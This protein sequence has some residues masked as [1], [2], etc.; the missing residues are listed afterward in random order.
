MSYN[1]QEDLLYQNKF[2]KDQE[3]QDVDQEQAKEFERY[4]EENQKNRTR[5]RLVDQLERDALDPNFAPDDLLNTQGIVQNT[6]LNI[7]SLGISQSVPREFLPFELQKSLFGGISGGTIGES[8]GLVNKGT[9]HKLGIGT[10][11]VKRERRTVVNIDSRDRDTEEYPD[12]NQFQI[13]L[14]RAYLNIKSIALITTEFPNAD[15]PVKR[16][17]ASIRNNKVVW[18]NQEDRAFGLSNTFPVYTADLTPGNYAASTLTD[19][20]TEKMNCVKRS[21]ASGE[22][23]GKNHYFDISIDLD[24]DIVEIHQLD[25]LPLQNNP[26]STT[27]QDQTVTVVQLN[28]PFEVGD[29]AFLTGLRGFVGG[30]SPNDLNGFHTVTATTSNVGNGSYGPILITELNNIIDFTESGTNKIAVV[31][32]TIFDNPTEL[33][34]NIAAALNLAG[35]LVYDVDFDVTASD[36]FTIS[37]ATT[38]FELNWAT[39]TNRGI[40]IGE[41]LGFD[42]T[43]D[44]TGTTSYTSD[45]NVPNS[46]WQFELKVDGVFT[47]IGGSNG[48]RAGSLLPFKFLFGS[49]LNTIGPLLGYPAED[50]S[51]DIVTPNTTQLTTFSNSVV[52]ASIVSGPPRALNINS[53]NHGLLSGDRI[54]IRDLVTTPHISSSGD[55]VGTGRITTFEVTV[56][57]SDNFTVPFSDITSVNPDLGNPSWG[58]SKIVVSHTGHGMF[59]GDTI[60]LYRATSI[61]DIKSIEIN[62]IPLTIKVIDANSYSIALANSFATSA[63]TGG[64]DLLRISA[65]NEGSSTLYGFN[66]LQDNT[67]D[68]TNLNREINLG[69]EDYVLLTCPQLNTL[70]SS[71]RNVKDIFAKILL[72]GVPGTRLYNTFLSNPKIFDEVP[73]N[74]LNTLDFELRRQDN[75]LFSLNGL[76]FSF[77]LEIVELI[78]EVRNTSFSSRRGLREVVDPSTV[79]TTSN[80]NSF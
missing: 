42:T 75:V 28:H 4:Y 77:S 29:K 8:D 57:D 15:Q 71:N 16:T 79:L 11:G 32:K 61:A 2:I 18:I 7:A 46:T 63:T 17:P 58:S 56:V 70:A 53:P 38:S 44:D 26:I 27:L 73:L 39:G 36:K 30:I 5:E 19:E 23:T 24:T 72:T 25:L 22:Y 52:S 45:T 43:A 80:S 41:T 1:N 14:D 6:N 50:S 55:L 10:G 51:S 34:S 74:R 9:E 47:D 48:G 62:N 31:G 66:G 69:G 12:A 78:D 21:T 60:R 40:S 3:L 76:D 68:G 37:N 54:D 33:A 49:D 67:S 59:T 65:N 20:M 35:D 13:Q 64:G